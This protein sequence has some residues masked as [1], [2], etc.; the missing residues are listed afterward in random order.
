MLKIHSCH[1]QF[2]AYVFVETEIHFSGSNLR[3]A[4]FEIDTT[5]VSTVTFDQFIVSLLN[6]S[7]I[8][9][10]TNDWPQTFEQ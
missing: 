10:K 3:T 7:S 1:Y 5:Q 8:P 4:L 2:T 9:L 6:K